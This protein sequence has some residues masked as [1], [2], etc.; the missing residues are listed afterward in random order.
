MNAPLLEVRGLSKSFAAAHNILGAVTA[1]VHAVVGVS[2]AV[3]PG[4]AFG[5]VG[6]SGCGKST[7]GR[8]LLRLVEPDAGSVLFKGQD[9][10]RAG[11]RRVR[12]LRRQ[13]QIIFQDPYSSLNP[14]RTIGQALSEPLRVHRLA[15]RRERRARIAA[16]LAEV[17]L[18]PDAIDKYPHEFSGGQRQRIGIARALALDPEL[19]VAD[20]PVSALDV[21]IQA[22]ILVLL[23][24]LQQRRGL[25]FVFISHDLGVVRHFCGSV[26]VMYLGH[27]VERGPVP[28][29]FDAPLHP[30]TQV[31]R[32]ASPVPDPKA[33][34][35]M[36]RLDGEVA[37]ALAP[38]PGCHFH[39]RCPQAMEVCRAV[40]PEWVQVTPERGVACHLYPAAR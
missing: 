33:R 16:L 6:E 4:E 15:G 1:R 20:E 11:A 37:S 14:R 9:V 13:M 2:F 34:V 19:I 32:N 5:L 40:Y 38:P 23:R 10:L 28:A 36:T 8:A 35:A 26:A 30:Y 25:S 39:P 12:R 24:G 21:S 7:T 17:G 31:L 29:I 18:P 27:I 22:Q 3:M